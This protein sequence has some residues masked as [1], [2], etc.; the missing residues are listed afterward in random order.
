MLTGELN[1]H[2]LS[3]LIGAVA[4]SEVFFFFFFFLSFLFLSGNHKVL[5][6]YFL[7][8]LVHIQ[9]I[10]YSSHAVWNEILRKLINPPT[11]NLTYLAAPLNRF[12]CFVKNSS[13]FRLFLYWLYWLDQWLPRWH[14]N[15]SPLQ[16]ML[17][18]MW[19]KGLIA[20][21]KTTY[22]TL[23]YLTPTKTLKLQHTTGEE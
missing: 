9:P 6:F 8:S 18:P 16:H 20:S 21:D 15:S 3:S 1:L 12:V 23:T 10:H 19:L 14:L 7:L 5:S 11:H 4:K 2:S 22:L 13:V 17:I